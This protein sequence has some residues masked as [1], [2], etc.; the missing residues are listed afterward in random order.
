ML[1]VGGGGLERELRDVGLEVVTSGAAATR[2]HQ[3]GI[4]G[5]AAAGAPTPS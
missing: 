2:M 1:V 5:W 4:D 3:E